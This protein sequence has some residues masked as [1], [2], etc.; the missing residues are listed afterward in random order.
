MLYFEPFMGN[1]G[2]ALQVPAYSYKNWA[3]QLYGD[4]VTPGWSDSIS[5]KENIVGMIDGLKIVLKNVSKTLSLIFDVMNVN[6][7]DYE[8]PV[9]TIVVPSAPFYTGFNPWLKFDSVSNTY[10]QFF[11]WARDNLPMVATRNGEAIQG[12][13]SPMNLMEGADYLLK[14]QM[15]ISTTLSELYVMKNCL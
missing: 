6:G 13:N 3:I 1:H 5:V 11:T 10:T 12:G 8:Q 7:L 15:F 4:N 9:Y 14:T 2:Y